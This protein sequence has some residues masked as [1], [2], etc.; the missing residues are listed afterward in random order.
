MTGRVARNKITWQMAHQVRQVTWQSIHIR[1]DDAEEQF[2]ARKSNTVKQ[3]SIK[4]KFFNVI[5]RYN[6][7]KA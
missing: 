1:R 2:N 6:L 3:V 4:K 7:K 5:F